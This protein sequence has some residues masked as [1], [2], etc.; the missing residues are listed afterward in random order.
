V[1]VAFGMSALAATRAQANY[2][3]GRYLGWS[4]D[5]L[6]GDYDGARAWRAGRLPSRV[7][8]FAL[9]TRPRLDEVARRISQ[10]PQ[11]PHD[12]LA[13][14]ERLKAQRRNHVTANE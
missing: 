8:G 5:P 10:P 7:V 12:L 14:I 1:V 2:Y 4:D 6:A 9:L 11:P 3:D 13:Q